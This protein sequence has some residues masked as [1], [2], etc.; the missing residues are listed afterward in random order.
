[1]MKQKLERRL[2]AERLANRVLRSIGYAGIALC[3]LAVVF[4]MPTLPMWYGAMSW[5]LVV[6]G[7]LSLL[8]SATGRWAG[9]FMGLPLLISAMVTFAI[10]TYRDSGWT[11]GSG[12]IFLLVAYAAFMASRWWDVRTVGKAARE[13]ADGR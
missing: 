5:F 11:N 8:G 12:S 9:E 4:V 1:M 2:N 13:Y 10:L 6:G 3:G 7:G